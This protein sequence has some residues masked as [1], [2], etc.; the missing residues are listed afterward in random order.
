MDAQQGKLRFRGDIAIGEL[1][2]TD[3]TDIKIEEKV[4]VSVGKIIYNGR[5]VTDHVSFLDPFRVPL[6][7]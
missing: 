2:I 7:Y 5:R 4:K 3:K 1:N 6:I